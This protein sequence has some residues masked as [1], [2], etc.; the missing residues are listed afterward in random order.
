MGNLWDTQVSKW[1][2]HLLIPMSFESQ[3]ELVSFLKF[4]SKNVLQHSLK[5]MMKLGILQ[6]PKEINAQRS[7]SSVTQASETTRI[8]KEV[9]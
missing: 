7:L 3:V 1:K 2:R 9:I 8:W 4:E 5:Q 6:T